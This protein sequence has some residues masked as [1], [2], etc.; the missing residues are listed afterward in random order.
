M[1]IAETENA[2]STLGIT[3][4]EN[5]RL[6]QLAPEE[7]EQELTQQLESYTREV[8]EDNPVSTP[9]KYWFD[10]NDRLFSN[11]SLKEIYN[12]EKQFD[13]QERGGKPLEGFRTVEKKL[14]QN[15]GRMVL[16]YSP[17]G[18]AAYDDNPSNPYSKIDYKTGQLYLQY[19]DG[20]RINAVALKVSNEDVIKQFMPDVFHLA[21]FQEYNNEE[22]TNCFLLTPIVGV[23]IDDFLNHDWEDGKIY[24]DKSGDTHYL[25]DVLLQVRKTFSGIE[26]SSFKLPESIRENLHQGEITQQMIKAAYAQVIFNNMGDR[27]NI[28]LMG[29]CG[30]S[31]VDRGDIMALLGASDLPSV[32]EMVSLY[33]SAERILNQD[34][35]IKTHYDDY[36]CPGC[37]KSLSGENKN[38]KGSWRKECE[39]CHAKLGCNN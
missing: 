30:G 4:E 1:I 26:K 37:G 13:S 34:T 32:N 21:S 25:S 7:R 9:Y 8:L 23:S 24:T 10:N 16:W 39:H 33:S 35:V 28:S 14:L 3:L 5:F 15:P 12:V 29:S 2:L 6:Q 19:F 36:A 18:P 20:N 17:P 31:K 38:D 27:S 11:P 22:K